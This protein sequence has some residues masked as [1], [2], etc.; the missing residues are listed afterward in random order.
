MLF[1][2]SLPKF[3]KVRKD[4]GNILHPKMCKI[5]RNI[6]ATFGFFERNFLGGLDNSPFMQVANLA[7]R[8]PLTHLDITASESVALITES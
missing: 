8:G 6:G 5:A 2:R 7:C 4:Q 3:A 1:C